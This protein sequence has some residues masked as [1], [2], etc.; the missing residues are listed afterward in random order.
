MELVDI[1]DSNF[2]TI[3]QKS[4]HKAHKSGLL[5]RT[6][7]AGVKDSRGRFLL[8]TQADSKQ[9]AGKYVF[10]MGGHVKAG[11]NIIDALKR[12]VLEEINL[13]NFEFQHK[14]E[15]FFE[16]TLN[17]KNENHYVSYFEIISDEMPILGDESLSFAYF[18]AEEL[19]G[20]I[21]KSPDEFGEGF[22]IILKKFYSG[23]N[24]PFL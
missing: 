17:G 20:K 12:E 10:P 19:Q 1:L 15:T 14:G 23:F 4:K 9:D 5:H 11:E 13:I 24:I 18:T 3:G 7:V 8:V 21:I 2:N 6:V 16:R 22:F